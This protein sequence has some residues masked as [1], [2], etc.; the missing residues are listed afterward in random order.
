M[1]NADEYD[2]SEAECMDDGG[3]YVAFAED[4]D[5]DDDDNEPAV[6]AY[7]R[8]KRLE[9]QTNK[10]IIA[11]DS[12]YNRNQ[13]IFLQDSSISSSRHWTKFQANALTFSSFEEAFEKAKK[14][15]FNNVRFIPCDEL[16]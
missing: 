13:I 6:L 11:C 2:M 3:D 9:K 4:E 5:A 10:F 8:S 15:K 7:L 14:L 12:R 16:L 1:F